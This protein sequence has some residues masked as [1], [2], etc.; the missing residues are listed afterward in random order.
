MH[1]RQFK[2]QKFPDIERIHTPGNPI[3]ASFSKRFEA[4]KKNGHKRQI[5]RR[6]KYRIII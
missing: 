3:L 4:E 1:G 5:I 2:R 6:Q